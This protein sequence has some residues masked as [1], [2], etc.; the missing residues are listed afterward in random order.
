MHVHFHKPEHEGAGCVDKCP[1]IHFLVYETELITGS[2]VCLQVSAYP[3]PV[4]ESGHGEV[5]DFWRQMRKLAKMLKIQ[6]HMF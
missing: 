1:H 5:S 2:V 3:G 6:P 4:G